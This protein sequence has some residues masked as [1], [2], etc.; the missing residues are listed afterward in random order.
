MD[1]CA[2]VRAGERLRQL[3]VA[4]RV[5]FSTAWEERRAISN[6][7]YARGLWNCIRGSSP[8][9]LSTAPKNGFEKN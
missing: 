1:D 3:L 8:E 7:R 5:E 4:S 9:D 6:A 2:S